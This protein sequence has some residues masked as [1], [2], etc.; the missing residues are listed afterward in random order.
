MLSLVSTDYFE[1]GIRIAEL[2]KEKIL[3]LFLY[4][5]IINHST[6]QLFNYF[7]NQSTN[8]SALKLLNNLIN[9]IRIALFHPTL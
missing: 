1:F 3:F 4:P 2:K 8:L 7:I 9:F 6:N 5:N